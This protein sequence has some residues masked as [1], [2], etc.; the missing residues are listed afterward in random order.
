MEY[1]YGNL[2]KLVELQKYKFASS[3]G[4]IL[5]STTDSENSI[6]LKVNIDQL[7]TLKQVRKDNSPKDDPIKYYA[8]YGYN[9]QTNQYDIRLGEEIKIDTSSS[10]D[11]ADR[12]ETAYVK[13]GEEQAYDPVTKE[14]LYE[15]DGVTPI[16][17]PILQEVKTDV[18]KTG[19]LV[20]DQIPASAI[21]DTHINVETGEETQ[22]QSLLDGNA[23]G[24]VY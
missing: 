13:V 6:D 2:N 3:D 14:P 4:T 5:V 15:D 22:I 21:V 17:V 19:Q 11:V 7:V 20:L 1:L 12:I 18:S 16:M 10:D 9:S 23:G 8:L 24:E